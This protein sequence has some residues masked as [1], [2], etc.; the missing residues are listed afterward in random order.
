MGLMKH[1]MR[2]FALN[3]ITKTPIEP[4]A[5][6]LYGLAVQSKGNSYD[7]QTFELMK[8]VL[9]VHSNCIDVGAY[10][11]EILRTIL[12]VASQGK[13][14][15]FEPVPENYRYL[16]AKFKGVQVYNLALSDKPG[17]ATFMHVVGR[18]AR[19]GLKR[20]EYPDKDQKVEEISIKVSSLDKIIPKDVP[21]H[22]LKIDV[23]GAELGV[24]KGARQLIKNHHPLI[25]FEH[26]LDKA[27]HY[28]TIPEHIYDLLV[29]DLGMKIS[30][31]EQYF[32]GKPALSRTSFIRNVRDNT[33]FYFMAHA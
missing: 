19:S 17:K 25:V 4:L 21:I 28:D 14:F 20:V 18:P 29:K 7:K 1:E 32:Q 9:D 23:E 10:R 3:T 15:A 11:G 31:M 24:L 6:K 12:E 5:R 16:A 30:L 22:F 13:H 33:E 27:K 2:A 8:K 26:E